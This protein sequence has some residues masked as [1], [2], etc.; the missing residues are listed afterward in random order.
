VFEEEHS[1]SGHIIPSTLLVFITVRVMVVLITDAR[2]YAP[3][4]HTDD[5]RPY[6]TALDLD[7]AAC[8]LLISLGSWI[9]ETPSYDGPDI[10]THGFQS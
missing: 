10:G 9:L 1:G 4:H 3:H 8:T 5:I 2:L 6:V 7:L